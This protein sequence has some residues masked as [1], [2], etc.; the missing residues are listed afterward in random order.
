MRALP[1]GLGLLLLL[2]LSPAL[3]P[4]VVSAQEYSYSSPKADFILEF[5][6]STWRKVGEPDDVHQH[7]EFVYGDRNDGYLRIRKEVLED[8]VS[9]KD[10]ALRDQDQRNRF[11]PGF[12][13]GKQ[14]SFNGRPDAFTAS[15]EF[16]QAGKPMAGRTYYLQSDPH[17]VYVL[18]FTGL[19][20]K[21][22]SIRNQTDA[23]ARSLKMK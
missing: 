2:A 15:Y 19:R 3:A 7:T 20:Q 21:L 6:S 8:G 12:V 10:F 22:L 17:T 14:E 1:L 23:I 16:T 9:V 4:A 13:D 11:L 5:P 18:R